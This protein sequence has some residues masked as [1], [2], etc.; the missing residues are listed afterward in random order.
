MKNILKNIVVAV[1][2]AEA[3]VLLARKRPKIIAITGS[4]GKTSTKDAIYSVIKNSVRVRKSEKS[5][6]SDIG[7]PLTVLGLP[8]S[9]SNMF[10]W[11]ANLF[12]G[13]I[14]ALFQKE[15]PDWLVLEIGVDRPGDMSAIVAW[16]KPDIVVLTRLPDMPVHVEYFGTPEE[17]VREKLQLVSALKPDGVFVYNHD[18]ERVRDVATTLRQKVVG[19][20]RYSLSDFTASADKIIY[21]NGRAVGIECT[22]THGGEAVVMRVEG[23]L[24]IQH[25]Y[26]YAAAAAV[27]SLIGVGLSEAAT[28][29]REHVPP[30]GRM[31]LLSGLKDTLIIDDT[32]NSSP[33]ALAKALQ[34]LKEVKGVTRKIAV[35]GDMLELGQFSV[36]AHQ[37]AGA[38]VAESAD[39]LITVGVRAHSIARGALERGMVSEQIFQYDDAYVAGNEL[40]MMLREGDVVLVKGSQSMRLERVVEEIMLNPEEAETMLVRQE[41]E[42]KGR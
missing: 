3:R 33:V 7:V 40:E 19:F 28:A 21:E 14:I 25:A 23:S 38:Q 27:G 22:L 11:I 36:Q 18:D 12:E 32:Y 9:S 1:L 8:N 35:L 2:T 31:R 34:A 16:V 29:L 4:V 10:G 39:I 37:E 6:N 30:P 26:N 15:Y 5:F 17:V 41:R 42:W 20:S 24:G 13:L